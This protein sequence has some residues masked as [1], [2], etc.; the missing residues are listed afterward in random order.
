MYLYLDFKEISDLVKRVNFLESR[1]QASIKS[2]P[3]KSVKW[4]RYML[5][6]D[7]IHNSTYEVCEHI[8]CL[9]SWF[10]LYYTYLLF[11]QLS[12]YW[13]SSVRLTSIDTTCAHTLYNTLYNT[14]YYTKLVYHP[15]N[16]GKYN[17]HSL[18]TK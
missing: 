7:W 10:D 15:W 3:N 18:G 4:I 8:C 17:S 9:C 16:K 11:Q 13:M 14:L 12:I 5:H 6:T 2:N 1:Y